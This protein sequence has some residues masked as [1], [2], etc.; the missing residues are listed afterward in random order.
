ML[1]ARP[2]ES[3]ARLSFAGLTDLSRRSRPSASQFFPDRSVARSTS[4]SSR[5]GG[6]TAGTAL[7]GT[8]LL[9]LLR[10]LAAD[11]RSWSRST[12]SSG[13][14]R[15]QPRRSSS[16]CGVST[17][18]PVR[19]DSR[20]SAPDGGATRRHR[21][22]DRLR[23]A[24]ARA[25]FGRR[26]AP[27]RCA[28]DSGGR[29]RARRS[30]GSHRRRPATRCYALEIASLLARGGRPGRSGALPVPE[31]PPDAGRQTAS[32]RCRREPA[33][34][35]CARAALARPDLSLVDASAL[36]ACGG[37]G[38]RPHRVRPADRLRAPAL[39]FGGVLARRR[40]AAAGRCTVRLAEVVADPEEIAP[41][42]RPGLRRPGRRTSRDIVEGAATGRAAGAHPTRRPS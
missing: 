21:A 29:F 40:A 13:S 12:T 2:A 3:E 36:A 15:R 22:G 16:R 10:E 7:V 11:G 35:C 41:P 25:A 18:E 4:L 6:P 39:R 38:A 23:Q 32:D 17:D 30:S 5:R 42:S 26:A 9:S 31:Q 33:T 1:E 8:A 34:R 14:T 27:H 37:G 24:R 20:R 28:R 19:A